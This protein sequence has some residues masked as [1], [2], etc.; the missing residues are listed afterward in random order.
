MTEGSQAPKPEPGRLI[1]PKLQKV[2]SLAELEKEGFT[3]FSLGLI[4][5]YGGVQD[6]LV[7]AFAAERSPARPQDVFATVVRFDRPVVAA[8]R[9]WSFT[10]NIMDM[11][12]FEWFKRWMLGLQLVNRHRKT[13][14]L[15]RHYLAPIQD[16]FML[17]SGEG[18]K[19]D[20]LDIF[21]PSGIQGKMVPAHNLSRFE[22][23][24]EYV[25]FTVQP[26]EEDVVKIG[27]AAL[28]VLSGS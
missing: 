22:D 8:C 27:R 23:A 3:V 10:L 15:A 24:P 21:C 16:P 19:A 17:D 14:W 9:E 12:N 2:S 26:P 25:R 20:F 1:E 13:F 4:Y 11:V 7:A 6:D 18:R 5:V 28:E